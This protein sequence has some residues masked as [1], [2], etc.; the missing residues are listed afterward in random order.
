ME[1]VSIE[2]FTLIIMV[3][4]LNPAEDN[5]TAIH[6]ILVIHSYTAMKL[7]NHYYICMCTYN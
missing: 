7:H 5:W 3:F 2:I 4:A 6:T 1:Y